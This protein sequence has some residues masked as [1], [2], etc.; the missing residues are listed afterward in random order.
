MSLKLLLISQIA[1]PYFRENNDSASVR[2]PF[3]HSYLIASFEV[4]CVIIL[5]PLPVDCYLL[6]G[7]TASVSFIIDSPMPTVE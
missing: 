3:M 5:W 6:R 2:I 4:L 1:D 7:R